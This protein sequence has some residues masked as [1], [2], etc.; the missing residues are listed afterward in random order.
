MEWNNERTQLTGVTSEVEQPSVYRAVISP[1]KLYEPVQHCQ[2][3][4]FYI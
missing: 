3:S 1:H 2:L 4:C